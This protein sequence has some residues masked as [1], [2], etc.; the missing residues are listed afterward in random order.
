MKQLKYVRGP[1][2][3]NVYVLVGDDDAAVVVDPGLECDDVIEDLARRGLKIELLLNT[4]G[5][6]D[7]AAGNAPFQARFGAPLLAHPADRTLR[8]MLV[9]QAG[10]FGIDA[11][12]TPEPDRLILG[13]E[14]LVLGS[15]E[16]LVLHTPGHTPG[17]CCFLVGDDL[18]SGD[19]LFHE[20]VGRTDLPGGDTRQL[21]ESIRQVLYALPDHVNVYPGHGQATT[22]GHERRANPFVHD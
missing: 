7:H 6:V 18:Y 13:G 12:P 2:V 4:H 8:E 19:T 3:N 17:G 1:F 10:W 22:I 9:E 11:Q 20:S 5:H 16:I 21:V 15:H 14:R